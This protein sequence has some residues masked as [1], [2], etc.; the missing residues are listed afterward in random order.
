[1]SFKTKAEKKS[2]RQQ[3]KQA[4]NEARKRRIAELKQERQEAWHNLKGA[5]KPDWHQLRHEAIERIERKLLAKSHGMSPF[6]Y[7]T[8]V[9]HNELQYWLERGWEVVEHTQGSFVSW[10]YYTMK[11]ERVV[12]EGRFS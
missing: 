9:F 1:M 6:V 7:N 2:E 4:S 8:K 12:L 10:Q 5:F 3:K 11:I